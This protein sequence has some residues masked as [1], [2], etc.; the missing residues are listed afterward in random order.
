MKHFLLTAL[1]GLVCGSASAGYMLPTPEITSEEIADGKVDVTWQVNDPDNDTKFFHV[2]VYKMHTA[3]QPENFVLAETDFDYLESTGTVTKHEERGAIWDYVPGMPGW[4]VKW[5]LYMNK[6]MGIDTFNYFTG[7]DND[8]IFGGAYVASPDYDLSMIGDPNVKVECELAHEANS[9]TGGFALYTFS[10][11]WWNEENI[12]YKPVVGQDHHFDD[13]SNVFSPYS[14]TCIPDEYLDRT[15]VVFYGKGY[16]ALWINKI[17]VSTDLLAGDKVTYAA[18][19]HKVE[20]NTFTIDTSADT[21]EDYVYAYQVC[22]LRED[23]DSYREISTIR[24]MSKF[25]DMKIVGKELGAVEVVDNDGADV[26]ISARDGK[27]TVAG[28]DKAE[29]YNVNGQK[30]Y[31]GDAS[32]PVELGANGV[33]IVKAG[34]KTCKVVL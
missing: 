2:I 34:G 15:R 19:V 32:A 13:L 9:V 8:D 10:L 3:A 28:A 30:V 7:S 18:S 5:P 16:S 24:F 21:P 22:G 12:D 1:A 25:S 33:F 4:Y 26:R 20:G 6:A 23:Y 14:E 31:S 29:I 17:K 11:D 27:I